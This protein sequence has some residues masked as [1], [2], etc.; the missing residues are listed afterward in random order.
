MAAGDVEILVVGEA[1]FTH[2]HTLAAGPSG[3]AIL[4]FSVRGKSVPRLLHLINRIII[5][6]SDNIFIKKFV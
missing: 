5:S 6:S 2:R 4:S 1:L 3:M